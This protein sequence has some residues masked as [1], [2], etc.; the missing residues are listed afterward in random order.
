MCMTTLL[1]EALI[2]LFHAEPRLAPRL[3]EAVGQSTPDSASAR[4]EDVTLTQVVPAEYRADA[5]VV[6]GA[7]R[8]TLGIVVEVQLSEDVRKRYTWPLYAMALRAKLR[9]P[10]LVLVVAPER[11]VATW[12]SR[13]IATGRG[14]VFQPT[15]VG[16]EVVPRIVDVE[17]AV[18]C[19]ELAV[20]SV[21]AHRGADD[22]ATLAAAAIGAVGDLDSERA[23][24][25]C[26]LVL[27]ALEPV[28][29]RALDAMMKIKW[30]FQSDFAKKYFSMGRDEGR[31]EGRDEGLIEGR[32]EARAFLRRQLER[33]GI[34]LDAGMSERLATADSST[35]ESVADAIVSS[36]DRSQVAAAV[37]RLL[38]D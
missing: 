9:C 16:P 38:A 30:E 6:L 5:V 11:R 37:R 1:H 23:T 25:Y 17:V 4:L 29:R 13:P 12:A 19:P 2:A 7:D 34:E 33:L 31:I 27:S 3:L 28:A 8:P 32:D 22:A 35:L 36:Q 26:D 20:L 15:V 21:L 10:T 14:S 24:F 18:R